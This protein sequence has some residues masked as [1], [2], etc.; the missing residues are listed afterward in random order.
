MGVGVCEGGGWS[1]A[2]C[3]GGGWRECGVGA[4]GLEWGFG[5]RWD[6][7]RVIVAC[8]PMLSENKGNYKS[9]TEALLK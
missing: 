9:E 6:I 3:K 8:C 5:L 4:L 1:G 7:K 2:G